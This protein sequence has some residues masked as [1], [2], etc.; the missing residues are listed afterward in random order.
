[1]G[2]SISRQLATLM[3]GRLAVVSTPGFGSTF[4][5]HLPITVGQAPIRTS[6]PAARF[7]SPRNLLVVE[8]NPINQM[9]IRSMLEQLA[10][11]ADIVASGEAALAALEQKTYD[12]ILMDIQLPG[13]SGVETTRAIRAR[14]DQ[15]VQPHII[16]LTASAIAGDRDRYLE[17]G[18][19]DYLSKPIRIDQ[20]RS[21]LN[22][23]PQTATINWA[24]LDTLAQHAG[25][26][27]H[28]QLRRLIG[29]FAAVFPQQLDEL[30]A[31][32]DRLDRD[33]VSHIAHMLRGGSSQV[34]AEC[35]SEAC[36]ALEARVAGASAEQ[37]R[38]MV[39]DIRVHFGEALTL[40]KKRYEVQEM[41][42][43]ED[44]AAAPI[45]HHISL[46]PAPNTESPA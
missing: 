28:V 17:A 14:G 38:A 26:S 27:G 36:G 44:A 20:L 46:R 43:A 19:D 23:A 8:D 42:D 41:I 33:A 3:G 39:S 18:L 45:P 22:V 1:M 35:L 11:P 25:A 10:C 29:L 2:L 37:I 32:S 5:L 31:A 13:I 21:V 9:V 7:R 34:G 40:L 16:A 24:H 4:S 15:I 12:A 30:E 6:A